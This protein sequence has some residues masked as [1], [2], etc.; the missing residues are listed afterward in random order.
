MGRPDATIVNF[1]KARS[2]P[3]L[4][5]LML[6]NNAKHGCYFPY[7]DIQ[8]QDG[9]WY[10]FFYQDVMKSLDEELRGEAK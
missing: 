4:R 6:R 1:L 10:C 8:K 5:R 3:G 9:H 7:F 2:L